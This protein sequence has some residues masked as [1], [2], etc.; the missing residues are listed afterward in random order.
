VPDETV[1]A[2]QTHLILVGKTGVSE[3]IPVVHFIRQSDRW[4]VDVLDTPL[5]ETVIHDILPSVGLYELRRSVD[6]A[7]GDLYL[8]ALLETFR[9]NT[10]WMLLPA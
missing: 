4:K 5:R 8:R 9:R 10:I 3:C 2:D 1:A 6:P 7:E